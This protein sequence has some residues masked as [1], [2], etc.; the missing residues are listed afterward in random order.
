MTWRTEIKELRKENESLRRLLEKA[1]N[2]LVR[3]AKNE[4]N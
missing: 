1:L 3:R 4:S 2:E